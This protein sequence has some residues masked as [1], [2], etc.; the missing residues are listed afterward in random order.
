MIFTER[1][2]FYMK[3]RRLARIFTV[4]AVSVF[5]V[6]SVSVIGSS[7][8]Y[9]LNSYQGRGILA[10]NSDIPSLF[11]NDEV[12]PDYKSYPPVI[13]DDMEYVPLG[14]FNGLP[15]IKTNYSDDQTNFYIQNK[16]TNA[17]ISFSINDNYAVTRDNKVYQT[18]VYTFYGVHYVPL[19][20]VCSTVGLGH[21]IY[22]D[23]E[24][25]FF[26]IKVYS[27]EKGLTAKE[28][29]TIY[30]PQLNSG[31]TTGSGTTAPD[32][33]A[34]DNQTQKP[35]EYKNGTVMLF[36]PSEGISAAQS[37]LKALSTRK[38]QATFFVTEADILNYPDIIRSIYTSG[39]TIGITF[40][41]DDGLYSPGVL[42]ERVRSAE[43]ALYEVAKIKTRIVYLPQDDKGAC[44]SEQVLSV[45]E[46]L[47]LCRVKLNADSK[48]DIY[49]SKKAESYLRSALVNIKKSFGS[50]VAY[51]K[52]SHTKNGNYALGVIADIAKSTSKIKVRLFDE[53]YPK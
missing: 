45:I 29:V 39:N 3:N 21:S 5:F 44:D 9:S 33:W 31:N 23:K 34:Q 53:T 1:K 37:T 46:K 30:A 25:K 28:L 40:D 42:E 48:T 47:G 24:N 16:K 19:K 26:A 43:A 18:S 6:F 14:L 38:L 35:P 15:N 11:R 22:N 13:C 27:N 10:E 52:M 8:N 36:Y 50:D 12:Y 51:M 2:E 7:Q 49:S 41:A 20:T 4:L 32:S 17:Y